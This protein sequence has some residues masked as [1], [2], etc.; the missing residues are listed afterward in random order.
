MR[1]KLLFVINTLGCG[2][3][4]KALLNLLSSPEIAACDCSLYVLLGQGELVSR[5]PAHVKLLNRDY[6]AADVLSARGRRT[7]ASRAIRLGMHRGALLRSLPYIAG[8]G[9]RMLRSGRWKA[10]KLLWRAVAEGTAPPEEEYDLAVAYLEGGATYFVSR[11]VRARRKVAFVHV[12]YRRAGYTRELDRG[13]YARFDRVFCVSDEVRSAFLQV[14]PELEEKVGVFHNLIDRPRILA[15]AEMG[16]G[17]TDGY[18]GPRILTVGRLVEQKAIGLSVEAMR[19]LRERGVRARWY[20]L[21]EGEERAALEKQIA[22]AGLSSDFLLPGVEE[23]PYPFFRQAA[24]Y[25]HCSRFEGCSIAVQEAQT[26]GKCVIVSDC[27]GN[28]GQVTDGVDG[29]LCAL[30]PAAIADAVERALADAALRRRLG[31]AAA[32]KQ[33]ASEDIGL[34][35]Q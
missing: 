29:L 32:A 27:S 5:L 1:K 17:F 33:F 7:A 3:T 35:F 2:G 9:M 15:M 11:A 23:N 26:L 22:A 21:G 28:R 6:C 16:P 19:I 4:E 12:D 10:E 20:V 30:T 34:I 14:Y 31:Q 8:N 24:L 13:C 18:D 25:V